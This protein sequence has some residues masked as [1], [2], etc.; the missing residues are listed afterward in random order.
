M[1]SCFW[2]S[3]DA[4]DHE[5]LSKTYLVNLYCPTPY[6]R[7]QEIHCLDCGAYISSCGCGFL[8]A[9]SGWSSAR[10]KKYWSGKLMEASRRQ[11]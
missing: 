7:G 6:C 10:W 1:A 9:V 11:V 4:C 8:D 3:V 2:A 5:R